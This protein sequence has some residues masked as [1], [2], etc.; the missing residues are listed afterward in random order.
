MKGTI[1]AADGSYSPEIHT[2]VTKH[3]SV[4]KIQSTFM[5]YHPHGHKIL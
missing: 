2:N 1:N 3:H 4:K 5:S